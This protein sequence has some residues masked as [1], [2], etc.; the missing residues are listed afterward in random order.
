MLYELAVWSVTDAAPFHNV[1]LVVILL[2]LLSFFELFSIDCFT[3]G[4]ELQTNSKTIDLNARF[5]LYLTVTFRDKNDTE[6]TKH[7]HLL[8]L[9]TT[10]KASNKFMIKTA[11][12]PFESR[13]WPFYRLIYWCVCVCGSSLIELIA[14]DDDF[15][16]FFRRI[17]ITF[18]R[19]LSLNFS[20]G[21]SFFLVLIISK[22]FIT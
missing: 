16:C 21:S 7:V 14:L 3:K 1:S 11:S 20:I 12:N 22:S 18:S 4:L 6:E 19:F 8:L 17:D 10:K 2:F 9:P 13:S 15:V 5:L